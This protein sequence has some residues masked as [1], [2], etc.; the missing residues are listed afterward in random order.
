MTIGEMIMYILA[1]LMC[2]LGGTYIGAV[3]QKKDDDKVIQ[4]HKSYSKAAEDYIACLHK[5]IREWK[6]ISGESTLM[7][8]RQ[9]LEKDGR[10]TE[11]IKEVDWILAEMKVKSQHQQVME[12]DIREPGAHQC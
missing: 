1:M 8:Y 9:I 5:I 10:F 2:V 7:Q 11:E 12:Q 4:S 3:M 6:A